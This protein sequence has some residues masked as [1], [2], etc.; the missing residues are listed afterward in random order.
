[1]TFWHNSTTGDG[2]EYWED[3]VAAFEKANPERHDQDPVDPERGDGRQA[4][5]RAQLRR[6]A[7]TS[8]WRAAAASSPTSSRP[9]RS[10]T[11]PSGITDATK[12]ALGGVAR[13]VRDRRQE[14][15]RARRR[16]CP[17]GLFYASDLFDA[18]RH[19][20]DARRRSTSSRP[21]T[22]KLKATGIA[23]IAVGAKDAWPAAHWYYNFALRACSQDVARRG[24][25][26]A[27]RSTTR[28]GST[29]GENL[30]TS[31]TTEPFNDGFLTTSAQQ[32]AGSS[33]GLVANHQAAMELMGAWDPGVIA[34]LTPDEQ[35]AGRPGVV[36]VPRGPG[37]DGERRRDD[38]RRR[39]LLVLGQRAR[40]SASTS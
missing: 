7:P 34:S 35:A 14:L 20:R 40:R 16:C 4:A 37:G 38:G 6:R 8:S 26:R 31:S 3:T 2:K 21:P 25:R 17:S 27:A 11:S 30:Q 32:G 29:A 39:R 10:W 22:T 9:A 23:P 19:H 5:D 33:A 15:R 28:A 12:S 36:P 1:M 13:R 18:G 24:G